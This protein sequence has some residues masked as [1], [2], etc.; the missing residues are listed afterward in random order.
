MSFRYAIHAPSGHPIIEDTDNPGVPVTA[1][2]ADLGNLVANNS[3]WIAQNKN[4]IADYIS[5]AGLGTIIARPSGTNFDPAA[6]TDAARGVALAA[7][8]TALES[9]SDTEL[10]LADGKTYELSAGIS[11]TISRECAIRGRAFV[12]ANASSDLDYLFRLTNNGTAVVTI[13]GLVFNHNHCTRTDGVGDTLYLDGTGPIEFKN[14]IAKNG[15]HDT[16][17]NDAAPSPDGS[18]LRTKG[19][20]RKLIE[21][22]LLIDAGYS[23]Y[24]VHSETTK[25]R[26][27]WSIC[28]TRKQGAYQRHGYCDSEAANV[29]M[30]LF[31]WDGGGVVDTVEHKVNMNLDPSSNGPHWL[32]ELNVRNLVWDISTSHTN[33]DDDAFFKVNYCRRFT[34]TGN[35]Q[36]HSNIDT[37]VGGTY[38]DQTNTTSKE[39]FLN[40]GM[41]EK[42]VVRDNRM[43]GII[44]GIGS[45]SIQCKQ[46]EVVDNVFG[47]NADILVALGNVANFGHVRW[48]GNRVRNVVGITPTVFCLFDLTNCGASHTIRLEGYNYF[49]TNFPVTSGQAAALFRN[50]PKI[51]GVVACDPIDQEYEAGSMVWVHAFDEVERLCVTAYPGDP[52]TLHL[53]RNL[54]R[55]GALRAIGDGSG[56]Y[57]TTQQEPEVS[58]NYFPDITG[59][60]GA[61]IWNDDPSNGAEYEYVWDGTQWT[62]R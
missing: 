28:H 10:I 49:H 44:K 39:Y 57:T 33:S 60:P 35:T 21:N 43:D 41:C 55:G 50:A 30:L 3:A 27:V 8:M 45:A 58:A 42:A 1:Y 23:T 5:Q 56:I 17:T 11:A 53:A 18:L 22:V 61:R 37:V 29:N 47:E 40:I 13:D 25:F 6:D 59:V 20:G 2:G 36:R 4:A 24:R 62:T 12:K 14:G 34:F 9:S 51:V 15:P 32:E 19:S 38:T 54:K 16:N 31:D 7:A 48:S 52:L 26:N 46:L